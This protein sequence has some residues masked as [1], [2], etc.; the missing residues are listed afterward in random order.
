MI[1]TC[2]LKRDNSCQLNNVCRRHWLESLPLS[3]DPFCINR[4]TCFH[5]CHYFSKRPYIFLSNITQLLFSP[6]PSIFARHAFRPK[7]APNTHCAG[8]K[9]LAY[10]VRASSSELAPSRFATVVMLSGSHFRL[11]SNKLVGPC[12]GAV[13][14]FSEAY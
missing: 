6:H 10:R 5:V 4:G 11:H 14:H 7:I 12:R 1:S 9:P 2:Q 3:M 13:P 8:S